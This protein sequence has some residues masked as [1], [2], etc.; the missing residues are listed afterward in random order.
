M[1]PVRAT[2]WAGVLMTLTCVASGWAALPPPALSAAAREFIEAHCANCHDDL[3][4]KGGLDLTA[5]QLDGPKALGVWTLVHDRVR[6]GEMPPKPKRRPPPSELGA[7]LRDLGGSL[8]AVDRARTAAEGRATRRRLNRYEFENA[9]RDLLQAPWLQIKDQLPEDGE[10]HR[11]NKSGEALDVSHIQLA[12]YLS[13]AE[14]AFRDVLKSAMHAGEQ[15]LKRYYVREDP[16]F[17]SKMRPMPLDRTAFPVLGTRAQPEV[18]AKKVPPSVGTADPATRELEA[19]GVVAS[20]YEPIEVRFESFRAPVGGR[21]RIRVNAYSIWVGPGP[22]PKWWIPNLDQVS[23]GRRHEPITLYSETKG[24]QYRRLGAFDVGTE[25]TTGEMEVWLQAGEMIRPDACR[26]FRSRPPNWVN[27]NATREGMPGVAFRW[28]EAEGPLLEEPLHPGY[29]V[30]FGDL[31]FEPPANSDT[32]PTVISRN[33]TEDAARLL[34]NFLGQVYRSPV[35]T[36]QLQPLLA[37]AHN[38]LRAGRPF[39]E[40]ML[41]AYTAAVCSTPFLY[42]DEKPGALDAH[43]IAARLSFFLIN[44]APDRG[45]RTAADSGALLQR[46]TLRR[47]TDRLLASADSRRF[48]DAFLDYWLDLRKMQASA[49]DAT[50]YPDYYLDDHLAESAVEETQRYFAELLRRD[51]PARAVVDSDFAFLNERLARHYGVAGVSGVDLRAVP[52]PPDS[53]RGGLMT[54]ASVLKV[55]ANGTTTSPVLRGVWIQERIVGEPPR[56]PPPGT[57][58]VEPD[59]RGATTIREQLAKHRA[60]AS[61]ASCHVKIDPPGFALESFDVMGGWRTRYRAL[62]DDVPP[63]PGLGHNG[64]PFVFHLALPVDCSGEM[65]D[66][67]AFADIREFKRLL[68]SDERAVARNLIHQLVVYATGAPVSFADRPAVEA[69]LDAARPTDYGVR[70]LIHALVQSEL[71]QRK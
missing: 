11:F 1:P 52:L 26:L 58:A 22:E 39:A 62:A 57:P 71:F 17:M 54:H 65:A 55:T 9:L 23:P 6:A 50:L 40:S 5:L 25:P 4:R 27:P 53:P 34:K 36:E 69:I 15:R 8:T 68:L 13:A 30:L 31:P 18:R 70:S 29:R 63:Q 42:L 41:D 46:E 21:Y 16:G 47:E 51:R 10:A 59:T 45:L 28:L 32:L 66:G 12:R 3:E 48:V 24:R 60:D 20:N 2:A 37:I 64:Q 49:P 67:R 56:P 19:M 35:T 43:A 14:Y 7:F 61:C 38:A 33:P 44:S